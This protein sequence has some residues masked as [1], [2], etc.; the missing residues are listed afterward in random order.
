MGFTLLLEGRPVLC[1]WVDFIC[2]FVVEHTKQMFRGLILTEE[3]IHELDIEKVDPPG[4][5]F[6]DMIDPESVRELAESIRSQGLHSPILVRPVDSRFEIVFGH[7][8]FLAHRLIGEVKIKSIVREMTDDQVFEA[9]A[10]ENDQREDLNP[11]ERARVYKRLRDKFKLSNRQIAQRMGRSPG[12]VDKYFK[13]LEV[14]EEFQ[15]AVARKKLSMQ[16]ALCLND[17]DDDEFRKFYFTSAVQNGVTL[18]VAAMW[19]ND[20]RKS[21]GGNAY[22]SEG[23]VSG[24]GPIQESLPMYGTCSCCLGPVEVTRIKYIPVCSDCEGQVRG[25]LKPGKN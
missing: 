21:R 19:V 10:V 20:W 18:D 24:L 22:A 13:L 4:D 23:G 25:A 12:V 8:R 5:A 3:M 17:I 2:C 7:R 14:P 1:V 11:M 6:R 15:D 9:R 16:V